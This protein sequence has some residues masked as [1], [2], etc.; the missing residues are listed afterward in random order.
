VDDRHGEEGERDGLAEVAEATV[1]SRWR[2]GVGVVWVGVGRVLLCDLRESARRRDG[3]EVKVK[4]GKSGH[5]VHS[6]G[7]APMRRL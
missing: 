6:S 5:T 3:Y 4:G 2:D 1:S 7:R